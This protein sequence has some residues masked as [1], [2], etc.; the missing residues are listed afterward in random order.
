MQKRLDELIISIVVD[1]MMGKCNFTKGLLF[2]ISSFIIGTLGIKAFEYYNVSLK[3]SLISLLPLSIILTIVLPVLSNK[4][5]FNSGNKFLNIL[6][7]I[8]IV[9]GFILIKT[10]LLHLESSIIITSL[11]WT[12]NKLGIYEH[13]KVT[14]SLLK[15][16]NRPLTVM[17][18]GV[19]LSLFAIPIAQ[20]VIWK[21]TGLRKDMKGTQKYRG[22]L[23]TIQK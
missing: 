15:L 3:Y 19:L 10:L 13:L 7:L 18:E 22:M 6:Y 17:V 5:T 14:L 21:V 20:K 23:Q 4:S 11:E 12:G 2:F 9:V 16:I 8:N 1:D